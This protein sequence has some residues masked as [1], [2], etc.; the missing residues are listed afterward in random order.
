M[1]SARP[2]DFEQWR[3][4]ELAASCDGYSE[5]ALYFK[6]REL[7]IRQRSL[8]ALDITVLK[9]LPS[10]SS[11]QGPI[12]APNADVHIKVRQFT[13]SK[14]E[15]I[16]WYLLDFND[17]AVREQ[18]EHHWDGSEEEILDPIPHVNNCLR[19]DRRE[20]LMRRNRIGRTK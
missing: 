8:S 9:A 7:L 18:R 13:A 5:S 6:S 16:A 10:F 19:K 14:S 15:V 11:Y 2:S 20:D 4:T 1:A 3:R 12:Y 17:G